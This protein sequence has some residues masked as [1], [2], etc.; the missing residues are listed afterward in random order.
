LSNN[1]NINNK[2]S[3]LNNKEVKNKNKDRNKNKN[4]SKKIKINRILKKMSKIKIAKM[5]QIQLMATNK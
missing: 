5:V 2:W 4:K 3:K 1:S